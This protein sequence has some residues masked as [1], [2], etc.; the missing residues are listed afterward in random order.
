[1]A[2]TELLAAPT[3][4]GHVVA[5]PEGGRPPR[6]WGHPRLIIGLTILVVLYVGSLIA[7][8][9]VARKE[10]EIFAGPVGLSPSGD[11]LLGTDKQGRDVLAL[12]LYSTAPTFNLVVFAGFLATL[13]GTAAGLVSGYVRGALDTIVRGST[14]IMLGIPAFSMLILVAAILGRMSLMTMGLV[15]ALFS[16][17]LV[18][19]AVR[20]QVLSL[21]EQ[22]FVTVA[23]LSNR[24]SL[25][26]MAF[27]LLPNML[28]FITAT[29]VGAVSGAL[30]T[31]IGL[32]LIGLG[33]VD[34][35]TL[36]L[37]LQNALSSGALSQGVWWWW[38]PPAA[39]LVLF[40]V[41]LFLVSLAVDE[42]S[43]PRLRKAA[44]HG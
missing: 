12:M 22:P 31:A 13:L 17:P 18:A 10:T 35:Q 26:I 33:P 27:E 8:A 7:R 14:D 40:F 23:R 42:I 29:F 21:R 6:W 5:L 1:M 15:I 4:T 30:A 37:T 28:T 25:A 32:Q 24:G 43:N 2:E 38:L 16:W 3:P 41:G 44:G 34:T 36:G 19:R 9:F 39:V 20:S 11:H